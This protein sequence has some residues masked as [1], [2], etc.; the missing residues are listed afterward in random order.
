M[1]IVSILAPGMTRS[2]AARARSR[3]FP[4]RD[5]V[6]DPAKPPFGLISPRTGTRRGVAH[7]A[8]D[9]SIEACAPCEPRPGVALEFGLF[10]RRSLRGRAS[11]AALRQR[12]CVEDRDEPQPCAAA[13][14]TDPHGRVRIALARS[15]GA[16]FPDRLGSGVWRRGACAQVVPGQGLPPG[17]QDRANAQLRAEVGAAEVHHGG[18]GGMEQQ[19]QAPPRVLGDEV[20]E[21]MRQGE[22]HVKIRRR[23]QRFALPLQPVL[24]LGPLATGTVPVAATVG[25]GVDP[26]TVRAPVE[27]TAQLAGGAGHQAPQHH[28]LARRE[29]DFLS[30]RIKHCGQKRRAFRFVVHLCGLVLLS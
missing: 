13:M 28:G 24:G 18:P 4:C 21:L 6:S 26:A 15:P 8:T 7:A 29:P 16:V 2:G 23:Q 25:H 5:T 30:P 11:A 17:V 9:C 27:V 1:L 12:G 22:D 10:M 3:S 19:V 20:V 14:R